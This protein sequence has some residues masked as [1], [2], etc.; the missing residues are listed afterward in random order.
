MLRK[1]LI[2]VM[3]L[4]QEGRNAIATADALLESI[5]HGVNE[6]GRSASYIASADFQRLTELFTNLDILLDELIPF[7]EDAIEGIEEY[8]AEED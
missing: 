5:H 4:D 3:A 2:T 8:N 7:D 1:H 6:D